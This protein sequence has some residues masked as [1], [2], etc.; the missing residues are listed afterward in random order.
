MAVGADEEAMSEAYRQVTEYGKWVL[1]AEGLVVHPEFD[2]SLLN[3]VY[4]GNVAASKESM[5]KL[6]SAYGPVVINFLRSKECLFADFDNPHGAYLC[7]V[8]VNGSTH[9]SRTLKAGRTST[10]PSEIPDHLR[11]ADDTLVYVSN[12]DA[13]V[14]EDQL[15]DIFS[16]IGNVERTRLV[17]DAPFIHKGYGYVKFERARDA[18]R[19]IGY[20]NKLVLYSRNMK[21]GPTIV[22]TELPEASTKD[23]PDKV[24]RIKRRIEAYIHGRGR[25]VVLRNL[26]DPS[27]AD[28]D[29]DQEMEREVRKY[30]GVLGFKVVKDEDVAVYCV[31]DS[32]EGAK[33]CYNM[34]NGRFFGGRRIRAEISEEELI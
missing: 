21:I 31:Y 26:I 30:G 33:H 23:I 3:K 15:R 20:N 14:D 22:K 5:Y 34:L 25:M 7:M 8:D 27:D 19:A 2:A 24:F 13:E 11:N 4:I 12:I 10:F 17:C 32:E 16:K 29:F 18:R 1:P 9:D 6:L 28:D